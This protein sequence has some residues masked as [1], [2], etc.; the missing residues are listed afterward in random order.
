VVADDCQWYDPL[1]RSLVST[2]LRGRFASAANPPRTPGGAPDDPRGRPPPP[3]IVILL[4]RSGS[5]ALVRPEPDHVQ[6]RLDTL[7]EADRSALMERLVPAGEFL[8][9]IR[10]LVF[11]KAAG[12]PLFIEEM[13]RLIR[14]IMRNNTNMNGRALA[15]HIIEVIPVSLRDLIQSRI[16]RLESHT[17]QVLQCASL[18]G[19]DFTFGLID[20]FEIIHEG[21]TAQLRALCDMRYLE[22]QPAVRRNNDIHYYF[23]HGLFR[24]VAYATLLEEQKRALHRALA[25]RLEKVF[26]DRIREYYELLAF[27]YARAAEPQKA[28][29]Y[30]VKAADRQM[31]LGAG[32]E[33]VDNFHQAIDLIRSMSP[34]PARQTLMARLLTRSARLHRLM[35]NADQATELIEGALE[36]ARELD[37][38]RL[39]LGARVE[40]AII[41]LW[42]GQHDTARANWRLP[43]K[44]PDACNAQS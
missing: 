7:R 30:L 40:Q 33:A 2:L 16:D 27:H 24:D 13:T 9:E 37:N 20:L 22:E 26:A 31:S 3:L 39:A 28:V 15:N 17:R 36:C 21:L 38:E 42:R 12:N 41:D 19:M 1:T 5:D 10:K 6:I 34:T 43:P 25:T 18:L 29:Y 35:G 32:P 14:H 4:Y 44:T 11:D 8:P 23:T